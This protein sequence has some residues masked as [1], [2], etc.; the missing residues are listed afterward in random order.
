MLLVPL[1]RP[2]ITM[3]HFIPCTGKTYEPWNILKTRGPQDTISE[4]EP[5]NILKIKPLT[6]SM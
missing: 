5:W 1:Q 2:P 6:K 4:D 3:R